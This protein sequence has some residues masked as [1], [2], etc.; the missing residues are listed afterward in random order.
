VNTEHTDPTIAQNLCRFR[1]LRGLSQQALAKKIGV[2]VRQLQDYE[3]GACAISSGQVRAICVALEVTPN[4][5]FGI[6][7]ATPLP[8][9]PDDAVRAALA[10]ERIRNPRLR[11]LAVGLVRVLGW[12]G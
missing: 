4:S 5:L 6:G 8:N 12:G 3:N 1:T 7:D 11:R 9:L 2:A 10:L